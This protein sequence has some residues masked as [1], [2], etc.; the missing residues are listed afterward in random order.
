MEVSLIS[1]SWNLT[2]LHA[3]VLL[4]T[5]FDYDKVN[6][7][8]EQYRSSPALKSPDVAS[9]MSER[10]ASFDAKRERS[11]TGATSASLSRTL[12]GPHSQGLLSMIVSYRISGLPSLLSL[13]LYLR[14]YCLLSRY[15]LIFGVSFFHNLLS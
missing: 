4:V 5:R 10:G 7:G 3:N 11:S 12:T 6:Y 15:H 13:S 1:F 9:W 14:A 8:F 2:N